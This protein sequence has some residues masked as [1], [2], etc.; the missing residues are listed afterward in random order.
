MNPTKKTLLVIYGIFV[1]IMLYQSATRQP[2]PEP[3]SV[4]ITSDATSYTLPKTPTISLINNSDSSITVDTCRDIKMMA[5]GEEKATLP[6]ALCR[7]VEVP[8][9]TTTPLIGHEKSDILAFQDG[10][11]NLP[12]TALRFTYT[13]PGK[14]K[15]EV[16]FTIGKA[17]IFRLFFRTVF[18]NPVYNF[19]AALLL[20]FPGHSLGWAI[21]TITLIIR[22]GLLVPQQ[23]ML[24]SQR[25]MQTIQP[26]IKSIQEQHKGDQAAIGMKMMELYKKEGVNPLGSCLPIVIQIPILIVLY[27][28]ILNIGN[29]SN[30]AHLYH[31]D[32]LQSFRD[33]S[34]NSHF[35]GLE[36]GKGGGIVGIILG[37]LTGGLQFGQM[38]LSQ[39]K[40]KAQKA[41]SKEE[42]KPK[43]PNMP[44]MQ[45]MQK[46]MIYIF[47]AMAGF[48]AYQYAAGIGL[49][50]L[51]GTVFMI[52]QQY[53]AN[54]QVEEKK[55]VI[56]DKA[57]NVIG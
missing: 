55:M 10:F 17:G 5:N 36:L 38:W 43:D 29:P 1:L 53:V 56:R 41:N 54:R 27:Q 47:P 28:V 57:G 18:Y 33:V 7:T 2:L 20:V 15:T 30:L 46:M 12:E 37:L 24:V 14:E 40:I 19:F 21:I 49:Y 11:Q 16:N 39:K 6:A 4:R 23:K 3:V 35:F 42:E 52:V 25:K 51:I 31:I 8:A 34:I 32:W 26:K 13:Q 22:L 45:Q 48:L 44:D 9:K 50:W